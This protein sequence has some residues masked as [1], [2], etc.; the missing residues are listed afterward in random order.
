M[1]V[2]FWYLLWS[3][4]RHTSIFRGSWVHVCAVLSGLDPNSEWARIKIFLQV[5]FLQIQRK[6]RKHFQ[7]LLVLEDPFKTILDPATD[8][9][10]IMILGQVTKISNNS[11]HVHISNYFKLQ[12]SCAYFKLFKF[13]LQIISN[14][15]THVH[16]S[17]KGARHIWWWVRSSGE[18][19]W[20]NCPVQHVHKVFTD[21]FI[22]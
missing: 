21:D 17:Q 10:G 19:L 22:F 1:K 11:V 12:Y 13:V 14:Y 3:Y 7:G 5:F 4:P 20:P 15:S 18:L 9:K 8:G 6:I 16:T 2:H